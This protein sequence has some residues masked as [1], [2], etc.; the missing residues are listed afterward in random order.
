MAMSRSLGATSLTTRSP[1]LSVPVVISSSPAIMRRQVVLPQPDG[2]TRTM[3][4]PSWIARFT[5]STAVTLPN[6]LVT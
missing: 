2:P 1:I 4:S 6:F 3:N 5:S